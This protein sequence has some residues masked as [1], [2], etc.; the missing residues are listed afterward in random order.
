MG[1]SL[2]KATSTTKKPA[3]NV[4]DGHLVLSLP[5]AVKPVIWRMGLDKIGTATFETAEDEKNKV[6]NLVLKPKKGSSEIIA[7]FHTQDE[8]LDIL[9]LTSDAMQGSGSHNTNKQHSPLPHTNSDRTEGK[10]WGLA[11]LATLCVLGLYY[12]M[13]TLIPTA[14]I[15]GETAIGAT[16]TAT[17]TTAPKN[18]TGVPVSADDFLSDF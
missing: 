13:T 9:I 5:H 14:T 18:A 6:T 7:S 16:P 11:L 10:K 17:G 8:A 15:V 2:N 4:V 1:F 12:Y 3:A